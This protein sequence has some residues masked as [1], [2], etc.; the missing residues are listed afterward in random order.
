MTWWDLTIDIITCINLVLCIGL[1]VD[2]SAH[3][4][5]HFMQVEGS[6]E[7]RAGRALRDMG[8]PVIN[9]A[10]STFLVF[11][12]LANSD[13]HVFL[14]F[15]KIFFGVFVFG[16]FNGLV[17]LPVLLSLVGPPAY[18]TTKHPPH[19]TSDE[20]DCSKT[21]IK[22]KPLNTV[23]VGQKYVQVPAD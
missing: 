9:G 5:L 15:F 10:F 13:S 3:V 16:V 20:E 1:C 7:E 19:D 17:F 22:L 23:N 11:I 2:Y 6:R 18:Y 21:D 14:S 4:A 8:P 12:F